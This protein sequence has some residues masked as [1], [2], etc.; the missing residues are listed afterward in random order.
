MIR[1]ASS[2]SSGL[3]TP[4][5]NSLPVPS[6]SRPTIAL[7]ELVAA[8]Q[9]GHHR[10]QAAVAA[11]D[12]DPRR[13]GPLP[14]AVQLAGSEVAATS[15]D[16]RFT[17]APSATLRVSWSSVPASLLVMTNSGSIA[18]DTSPGDQSSRQSGPCSSLRPRLV[19]RR[20]AG[21]DMPAI[22]VLGAQRGD[23]GKGKATDL[24]PPTRRSTSSCA[25]AAATMRATDRG[26]RRE[27][28]DPP[29][30]ERHPTPG[31]T[32]AIANGVGVSPEA[33]FRELDALPPAAST[34]ATRRQCERLCASRP[35]TRSST[36]SPSA[37]SVTPS[38]AIPAVGS[39]RRTTTDQPHRHPDCRPVR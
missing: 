22:V 6:G 19:P 10:V 7:A 11:R 5:A 35:T 17:Q 8:V 31:A 2:T 4:R 13:T 39:A 16:V 25:P 9:G 26:Q 20:G 34:G 3:P 1:A 33:L 37:S 21:E 18:A 24:R 28:R 29:P 36:R 38:S 12:H 27:V 23:E 15:T 14:D 32:C 30:A